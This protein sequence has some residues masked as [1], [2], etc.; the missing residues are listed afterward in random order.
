MLVANFVGA[1]AAI[2]CVLALLPGWLNEDGAS[3]VPIFLFP[4][5][6]F[7][8]A[9][10]FGLLLI[11]P[12]DNYRRAA[13]PIAELFVQAWRTLRDDANFRRLAHCCRVFRLLDDAVSALPGFGT[14]IL[15]LGSY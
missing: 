7:M 8:A 13:V 5:L 14:R 10:F 6:C 3:F 15:G 9:S 2:G 1:A 11:E 4:G 12:R